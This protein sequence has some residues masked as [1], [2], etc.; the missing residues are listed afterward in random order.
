MLHAFRRKNSFE[1]LETTFTNA[2][3]LTTMLSVQALS[4]YEWIEDLF[5]KKLL[6]LM[7]HMCRVLARSFVLTASD[8]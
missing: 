8:R 7:E 5:Q 3:R 6:F 4:R 2:T 1:A